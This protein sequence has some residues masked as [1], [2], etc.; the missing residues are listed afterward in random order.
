MAIDWFRSWHGAPTDNKWLVIAKR[1]GVAPGIVSAIA[2]ALMDFASRGQDRGSVTGFDIEEYSVFSGFSE[3]QI[4]SVINAL[5][6]KK[7][8]EN[9]RLSSWEKRQPKRE[10]SSAER[11]R[12]YRKK[13]AD[14]DAKKDDVTQCDAPEKS[15]E[16]TDKNVL[17]EKEP[18]R[19]RKDDFRAGEFHEFFDEWWKSYPHKIGKGA[20]DKAYHKALKKAQAHELL[21]GIEK[22]KKSKPP[23]RAWCNPATWLNQER[24]KDEPDETPG[25]INTKHNQP[26][27]S[28]LAREAAFRGYQRA[29]EQG[30]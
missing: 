24:W 15:R 20:A 26:S 25:N 8:I 22:Y 12:N 2:W 29:T 7:I 17:L 1:S 18:K 6:Q 10:D 23:D 11:T 16:D 21:D 9:G 19:A 13:N 5:K 14:C 3:E 30:A 27:K 4:N 28:Q